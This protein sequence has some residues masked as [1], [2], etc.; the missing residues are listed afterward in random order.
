MPDPISGIA[1]AISGII[2][3]IAGISQKHQGKKLLKQIGEQPIEQ[4]PDEYQTN[5]NLAQTMAAQGMPS[6]QYNQAMRNIQR[7]QLTSL[8]AAN[9]RRG[10]LAVLPSL[11]AGSDNATLG[12]DAQSANMRTANQRQLMAV[13]N[14]VGGVKRQLFQQNVLNPYLR[15]YNYAQSLVGMGNQNL[16]GGIDKIATGG[17]MAYGNNNSSNSN[18]Y[19]GA[20]AGGGW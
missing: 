14:Q 1:G 4:L 6:E 20:G 3:G 7:Q 11:L 17:L 5:Q 2:G 12:L 13:N 8:R 9:D 19:N 10:G 15:K 18:I 16:V